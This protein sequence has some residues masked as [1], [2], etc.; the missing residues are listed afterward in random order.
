M[1]GIIL[2]IVVMVVVTLVGHGIWVFLAWLFTSA[3]EDRHG[4]PTTSQLSCCARCGTAMTSAERQCSICSWPLP[5]A[6][7]D[8]S[9]AILWAVGAQLARYCR[10]GLLS[11]QTMQLWMT[12]LNPP[13]TSAASPQV[14]AATT[15]AAVAPAA[16]SPTTEVPAAPPLAPALVMGEPDIAAPVPVASSMVDAPIEAMIVEPAILESPVSEPAT[17]RSIEDR[18]RRYLENRELAAQEN[19]ATV[20]LAAQATTAAER[21]K[22]EGLAKLLSAF[23]EEKNIRWGE[24]VGGLLIVGCTVALVISFWS[25]INDRP[26]LKFL[27]L[28]GV[29]AAIF[30]MGFYTQHSWKLR[31]TSLG[32]Q[33]IGM[34]LVPLNFLAIAAFTSKAPPSDPLSLGG[35]LLSLVFFGTLSFYAARELVPAWR[36]HCTL[37]A[38]LMCVWQLLTRRFIQADATNAAIYLF[39]TVP[40]AT[41]L[42]TFGLAL[43]D[44]RRAWQWSERK[45]N[46]LFTLLGLTTIGVLLP[47]GVLLYQT[48]QSYRAL[49][50]LSPLLTLLASPALMLG[51][52]AMLKIQ[53][54]S[55]LWQRIISVSIGLLGGLLTVVSLVLA[56]PAPMLLLPTLGFIAGFFLFLSIRFRLAA[57]H[58]PACMA[59]LVVLLILWQVLSGNVAL[60]SL[61]S[62]KLATGLVSGSSGFVLIGA[63]VLFVI[64]SVIL[65]KRSLPH[66]SAWHM[67]SA[68][69]AATLGFILVSV[70]GL[71]RSGDPIGATF[72]YLFLAIATA[73]TSLVTRRQL[74]AQLASALLLITCVQA[75]VFRYTLI[76]QLEAPWV[77]ALLAHATF[78]IVGNY[79][80]RWFPPLEREPLSPQSAYTAALSLVAATGCIA[81]ASLTMSWEMSTLYVS[82]LTSLVLLV[83]LLLPM[84]LLFEGFQLLLALSVGLGVLAAASRQTWFTE[85]E[86]PYRHPWL[87]IAQGIAFALQSAGWKVARLIYAHRWLGATAPDTTSEQPPTSFDPQLSIPNWLATYERELRLKFDHIAAIIALVILVGSSCYAVLPG[88]AQEISPVQVTAPFARKDLQPIAAEKFELLGA[89]HTLAAGFPAAILTLTVFA[90]LVLGLWQHGKSLR[91]PAILLVLFAFTLQLATFWEAEVAT[92]SALRWLLALLVL[93]CSAVYLLRDRFTAF[94]SQLGLTWGSDEPLTPAHVL[95]AT[96]AILVAI[97]IV[98][99]LLMAAYISSAALQNYTFSAGQSQ[100][101]D[102]FKVVGVLSLVFASAVLAASFAAQESQ[103]LPQRFAAPLAI[104]SLILGAGPLAITWGFAIAQSLIVHPLLGPNVD[105]WFVA[106]GN[107]ASFGM[108]LAIIALTL[109]GIGAF[110]RRVGYVYAATHL[111]SIVATMVYLMLRAKM[112]RTLGPDAWTEVLQLNSA[113]LGVSAILWTSIV[114]LYERQR[115][116]KSPGDLPAQLPTLTIAQMLLATLLML[117]THVP[118]YLAHLS[119]PGS[120]TWSTHAGGWTGLCLLIISLVGT[121]MVL[122][123]TFLR[124]FPTIGTAAILALVG[125][126]VSTTAKPTTGSWLSHHLLEIGVIA[127]GIWSLL[128]VPRS[129]RNWILVPTFSVDG[130]SPETPPSIWWLTGQ[131]SGCG[132]AISGLLTLIGLAA[133]SFDPWHPLPAIAAY[134]T[135]A[136]MLVAIAMINDQRFFYWG[137]PPL[138]TMASYAH[139]GWLS[140]GTPGF[141]PWILEWTQIFGMTLSA[142]VALHALL[143]RYWFS[144]SSSRAASPWPF[145]FSHLLLAM[146]IFVVGGRVAL[147]LMGDAIIFGTNIRP[148]IEVLSTASL[149]IAAVALLFARTTNVTLILCYFVGLLVTAE[150]VNQLDTRGTLFYFTSTLALAAFTVATSYLW[151][152]RAKLYGLAE[153]LTFRTEAARPLAGS[154]QVSLRG[155]GLGWLV[156]A[157]SMLSLVVIGLSFFGQLTFEIFEWRV[158]AAHAILAQAIAMAL[159][160][161]GTIRT[162]LQYASLGISVLFAIA[163]GFAFL[164][165]DIVAPVLHRTVTA[166]VAISVMIPVLGLGLVKL[167]RRENEW[168]QAAYRLLPLLAMIAS[169]LFCVVLAIETQQFTETGSSQVLWPATVA[170]AL[171]LLLLIVAAI[172]AAVLPGRDPFQLSE[173]GRTAYV[174]AAELILALLVL[175]FRVSMPWL[176]AGWFLQF[177]PLLTIIVAF[178]GVGASEFAQRYKLHVLAQPLHNTASLLPLIPILGMWIVPSALHGSAVLLIVASLYAALALLR[179]SPLFSILALLAIQGAWWFFLGNS[180]SLVIWKHPQLWLIPPT[181]AVLIATHF[182]RKRISVEQQTTIRYLAATVLYASSCADIF[183]RGVAV[184]PWLPLV[185]AGLS[186]LGVMAGIL[187]R[188]RAFLYLGTAFLLV[189]I[190]TMI[191]Y[192][193][194]ELERTWI[195]WV[196]G[197]VTGILIITLFGLFEK[198]RNDLL[199]L[200]DHLKK[201]DA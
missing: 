157:T 53:K 103:A 35:E 81:F 130:Q 110:E 158:S 127:S 20:A 61:E 143:E 113:V 151:S 82:W 54:R 93:V 115:T 12:R 107:P 51:V 9:Q 164:P 191:W 77:A 195:W 153:Q 87:W 193:A 155:S 190:F 178:I 139:W 140:S 99:Y 141:S 24:L 171:A 105:S 73:I 126:I 59:L 62:E 71:G 7:S 92:T 40:V 43:I 180:E 6:Q 108:P 75:I 149:V 138:A 119:P 177:W 165:P 173:Q 8:R 80:L 114:A 147:A 194:V 38:M 106:I 90:A 166:A 96:R 83:A 67:R 21:P 104:G 86:L 161:Q 36:W 45:T 131:A 69:L 196:A 47:L 4:L 41:Y 112:S 176:F 37:A 117:L 163:A 152:I 128:L 156:V 13:P 144:R 39:A 192:A 145:Q 85:A 146:A 116:D 42:I 184:A 49:E 102:A 22:R 10:L 74:L 2:F 78:A 66:D 98:P 55:L 30:G 94:F 58:L 91:I 76:H 201:W 186:I 185:L 187:L 52:V 188:V 162:A 136:G 48:Q 18:A 46:R 111:L 70:A 181:L 1:A 65:E 168:T 120:L 60:D 142:C 26:L 23:L 175:H 5:T 124:L 125:V 101:I 97:A 174:Y 15:P 199:K 183:L 11:P 118:T 89:P 197:I 19:A 109:L 3:R 84:P 134:L 154:D 167:T 189:A 14:E 16:E 169:I 50:K 79:S 72:A 121:W 133:N 198:K 17:P 160:A 28:N 68:E 122:G 182:S 34:L 64:S 31:T 129:L 27:L 57:A 29:T 123:T 150:F 200:V 137:V 148:L 170:V 44:A 100:L 25:E 32:L 179:S 88:A 159:L 135:A 33:L 95:L 63:A 56:W 132:L 172:A